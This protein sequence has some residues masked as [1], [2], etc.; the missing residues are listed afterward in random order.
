MREPYRGKRE[1][2]NCCSATPQLMWSFSWRD[3]SRH[4]VRDPVGWDYT[5]PLSP[6]PSGAEGCLH[7]NPRLQYQ[8]VASNHSTAVCE[9]AQRTAYFFH[10]VSMWLFFWSLIISSKNKYMKIYSCISP[11]EA[12]TSAPTPSRTNCRFDITTGTLTQQAEWNR[13]PLCSQ[14]AIIHLHCFTCFPQF[15]HGPASVG[16]KWL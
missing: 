3:A 9:S 8:E 14:W 15:T 13:G 10:Y 7:H 2:L 11:N 6:I 4:S 16:I 5:G 12:R 1:S